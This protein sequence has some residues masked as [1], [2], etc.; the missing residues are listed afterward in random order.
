MASVNRFLRTSVD[1]MSARE[2]GVKE[3]FHTSD[4]VLKD[5]PDSKTEN[6]EFPS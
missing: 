5:R 3:V 2:W 6:V 4:T 1:C